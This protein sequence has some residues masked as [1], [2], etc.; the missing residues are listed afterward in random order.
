MGQEAGRRRRPAAGQR[1]LRREILH[2]GHDEHDPQPRPERRDRR[3]PGE[4]RAAIRASPTTATAAS[5]RC[6]ANVVLDIEKDDFDARLRRRAR[7]RSRRKLDTDLTAED[8]KAII[9]EY[10]K[11]VQK[12]TGK[13]I[14]RRTRASSSC[15]ARDAVFRSWYNA[16]AIALPQD[17]QH[18]RRPRHRRQ[19]AG[20]G[21]R[22]PGRHLG[23]GRRLHAQSRPPARR[24]STASSWS[25]RRAKT[26]WPASARR[27]R[28]AS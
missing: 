5:S 21:V 25:T 22:Q 2:A 10:K 1:P 19:R 4:R 11:L 7:R 18:P 13:R 27:S 9:G 14:S 20:D 12:K 6:S 24:C 26:W 8:L 17:E 23:H 3:G 15:M 28:S 16:R